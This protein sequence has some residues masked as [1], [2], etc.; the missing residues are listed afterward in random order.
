[1][2]VL[3]VGSAGVVGSALVKR[4]EASGHEVHGFDI[5]NSPMQDI[6]IQPPNVK[7]I[8]FVFFLAYDIGGS[9]YLES[10]STHFISNNLRIMLN[11]FSILED[12][13]FV[14]ASSQMQ[15]MDNP[16][17][18]LKR[19]GEHYTRLLNGVSARFWNVY[20]PEEVGLKSHVI[21]DFI[22]KNKM[23]GYIDL[24]TDGQEQRQFLHTEDC[25]RAL[26]AIMV[27]YSSIDRPS[28]DVTSFEWIKII[29]LAR[30]ISSDVRPGVKVDTVQTLHN[31][32]DRY[33]LEFWSGPEISIKDG[34]HKMV[35]AC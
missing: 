32:P 23:L 31:E 29:D 16:Y 8:D 3:V 10:Q 13:P 24:M 6:R 30:L 12:V 28:V 2:R 22:H 4:L 18:A 7:K 20:G 34:I 35:N 17:G 21:P 25:A 5:K 1:M 33:I 27:N 19:L 14:F 15:N 26:E 11:M 9:K